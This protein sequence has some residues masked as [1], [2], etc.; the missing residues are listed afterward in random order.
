MDG[1]LLLQRINLAFLEVIYSQT[2]HRIHAKMQ[3]ALSA[4]GTKIDNSALPMGQS[5]LRL[6][7]AKPGLYRR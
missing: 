1:M 3:S 4:Y 6:P 7:Q 2:L 5:M